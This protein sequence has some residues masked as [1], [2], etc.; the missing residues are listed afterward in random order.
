MT[1]QQV[2]ENVKSLF[3]GN[4]E[5]ELDRRDIDLPDDGWAYR[6]RD[7]VLARSAAAR[8]THLHMAGACPPRSDFPLRK[9]R[10]AD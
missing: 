6:I 8:E 10:E 4:G 9:S 3:R 2:R 7:Q 5:I 1:S